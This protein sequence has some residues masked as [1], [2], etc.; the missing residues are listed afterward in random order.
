MLPK[1]GQEYESE[2][3]RHYGVPGILDRILSA[4][5]ALGLK[6]DEL[7]SD[8]LD[9]VS[10]FHIGGVGATMELARWAKLSSDSLVLDVGSGIGGPARTLA[11]RFGCQVVGIDL[12]EAYL[13]VARGLT[14]RVGL[15]DRVRFG[16]ANALY[17]PFAAGSFDAV[18]MQHVQM[19]IED[20]RRLT[21]EITRVLRPGGQLLMHSICLSG[22]VVPE[23]VYPVPWA[24]TQGLSFLVNPDELRSQF[25]EAGM[26]VT[27]WEDVTQ[28]SS[29][30]FKTLIGSMPLEGPVDALGV[31]LLMN[32]GPRKLR[33]L[34]QNLANGALSVIQAA[35]HRP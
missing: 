16:W 6:S 2:V 4:L 17:L 32:D 13:Q 33:N 10:H 24:E 3:Q 26:T 8:L 1:N 27:A 11:S 9:S 18:W 31:H 14:E 19:N 20:K 23:L 28:P 15:A 5:E 30:F 21:Q 7:S 22:G 34:Y 29:Q 25:M 12:T 35:W